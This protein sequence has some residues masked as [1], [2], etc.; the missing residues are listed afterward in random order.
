MLLQLPDTLFGCVHAGFE[1]RDS[2]SLFR[3]RGVTTVQP[4]DAIQNLFF[5]HHFL[6]GHREWGRT[7][8]CARH[9]EHGR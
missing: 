3:N 6:L 2:L 1:I 8:G 5:V 9:G 7:S 4:L